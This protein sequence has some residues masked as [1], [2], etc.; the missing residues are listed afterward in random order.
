MNQQKMI[1]ICINRVSVEV[2]L[3]L[4]LLSQLIGCGTIVSL[5]LEE[6]TIDQNAYSTLPRAYSGVILDSRCIHHPHDHSPNNV[7]VFCLIDL[8]ISFVLDTVL[9]PYT[10]TTQIMY[11]SYCVNCKKE[12]K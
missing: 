10:A 1:K 9:L 2:S 5:S 8:P 11:G 7:E 4:I 12:D 6:E 3:L